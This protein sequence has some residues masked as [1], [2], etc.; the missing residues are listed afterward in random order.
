MA[1]SYLRSASTL[2][3]QDLN[4]LQKG[5][6]LFRRG[7][8]SEAVL[9]LEAE[10]Q[11]N[12]GNAEA[13]RLLGT[14]QAENDDDQQV[15]TPTAWAASCN[16]LPWMSGCEPATTSGQRSAL[17]PCQR[18]HLAPIADQQMCFAVCK[19]VT[20]LLGDGQAILDMLGGLVGL[21]S[22]GLG[23]SS[24]IAEM[25]LAMRLF[26]LSALAGSCWE[27]GISI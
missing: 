24:S 13:W 11:R 15:H 21:A 2:P 5:R 27:Q 18:K 14:V 22:I 9:A 10:V 17:G 7:L 25:M 20:G 26:K 8:L 4:S 23:E 19:D 1:K 12:P 6:E 16:F 3:M